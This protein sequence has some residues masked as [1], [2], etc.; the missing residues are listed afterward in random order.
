MTSTGKHH[1]W[2]QV[3]MY[4]T[5]GAE[6]AIHDGRGRTVYACEEHLG[7]AVDGTLTPPQVFKLGSHE[8]IAIKVKWVIE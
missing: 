3:C 2:S 4:C 6:V 7:K 1:D 8:P 5:D